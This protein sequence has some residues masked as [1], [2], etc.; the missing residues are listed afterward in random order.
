MRFLTKKTFTGATAAVFS[1]T[2]VVP[3]GHNYYSVAAFAPLISTATAAPTTCFTPR[4]ASSVTSTSSTAAF[5]S[6]ATTTI[7]GE[8]SKDTPETND[9]N[10]NNNENPLL[11]DWSNQPYNLPPFHLIKP[12]HYESAL[13]IGM[14]K[15]IEG[16][17]AIANSDE[18]PTFENVIEAYDRAGKLYKKVVAVYSNMCSSLNTPE[19]QPI[20]SKM[21]PILSKHR[22][23]C[24]LEI[25]GL[26]NRIQTIYDIR[27]QLDLTSEQQ[28]LVERTLSMQVVGEVTPPDN[29]NPSNIR[30]FQMLYTEAD[31]RMCQHTRSLQYCPQCF[32]WLFHDEGSC[33][34]KSLAT[35]SDVQYY[36]Q[37]LWKESHPASTLVL[38]S[39]NSKKRKLN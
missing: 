6:S 37:Y 25:P 29:H 20:Q 26:F 23:Q 8:L 22:S 9:D 10:D 34:Y 31:G 38:P 12:S 13:E 28:R 27:T 2:I 15:H 33:P 18:E 14:E 16:L 32:D 3:H 39:E 7:Q 19:L 24:Y 21:A 5:S 35:P 4:P 30:P 17:V 11:Q 1:T 36:D